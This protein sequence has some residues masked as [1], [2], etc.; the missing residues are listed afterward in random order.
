MLKFPDSLND[1][2]FYFR[3]N[4]EEEEGFYFSPFIPMSL[5]FY[6]QAVTF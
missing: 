2:G 3:T 5:F 1:F 6:L 4:E